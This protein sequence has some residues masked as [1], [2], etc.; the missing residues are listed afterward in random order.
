[1]VV[2]VDCAGRTNALFVDR[3][4]K[5]AAMSLPVILD[6][7]AEEAAPAVMTRIALDW[8]IEG[9]SGLPHLKF[10]T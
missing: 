6:P 3:A 2:P 10:N 5:G 7:F 4:G 9:T 8:M 1:M